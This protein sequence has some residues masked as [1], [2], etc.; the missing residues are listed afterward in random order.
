MES[1]ERMIHRQANAKDKARIAE[2]RKAGLC[3]REISEQTG[4]SKTTCRLYAD[5]EPMTENQQ[6][7]YYDLRGEELK[8]R[9]A[10]VRTTWDPATERSRRVFK[11]DATYETPHC[12]NECGR[13]NGKPLFREPESVGIY[14]GEDVD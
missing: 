6:K 1:V 7:P 12:H 9:I 2:L 8:Q 10:A 3:W 14:D 4:F 11:G 13:M 5:C